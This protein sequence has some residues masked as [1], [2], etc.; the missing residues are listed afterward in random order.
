MMKRLKYTLNRQTLQKLYLTIIRPILEYGCVLFDNCTQSESSALENVQLDA[1]R[2]SVGAFWNTNRE[3][4]LREVGWAKLSCRRQYYK[5][6]L[7]YKIKHNMVPN[8]LH[9]SLV[10]AASETPYNLRQPSRIRP[11]LARTNRYK[12]SFFPSTIILWNNLSDTTVASVTLA[13]FKSRLAQSLFATNLPQHFC[14]GARRPSI[15]H[16]R[17]RLGHSSLSADL[18]SHGL[19]SN[20]KCDCGFQKETTSHYFL[21][22]PQHAAHRPELLDSLSSVLLPNHKLIFDS[23]KLLTKVILE[24]STLLTMDSNLTIFRA[25]QKYI[26]C[27]NRFS[28]TY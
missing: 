1:A 22:C 18:Y 27:T 16:T 2:V 8:Y 9:G 12:N 4:L 17:L 15:F 11:I 6:V 13:V 14:Y 26:I 25:V 23:E 21:N 28:L 10:P 24:G 7:F 3:K 5:L 20:P 19:K